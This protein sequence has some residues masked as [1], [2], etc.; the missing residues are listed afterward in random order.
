MS[1]LLEVLSTRASMTFSEFNKTFDYLYGKDIIEKNLSNYRHM[2][3]RFLEDLGHCEFDY[4]RRKVF[5]CKPE[6]ILLPGTGVMSAVLTGARIPE[7]ITKLKESQ[8][9]YQG[10]ITLNEKRQLI[11]G[12][13]LPDVITIAS[14]EK[15]LFYLVA[16]ILQIDCRCETPAA[17]MLLNASANI[18]EYE[19]T[20]LFQV[21]LAK[22]WQCRMFSTSD[23]HF[24]RINLS[25]NVYGLLEF[26]HPVTQQKTYI[27]HHNDKT[28]EI[29]K[30]WGRY[31]VLKCEG[32]S[33]LVFD[34]HKQLLGVPS[35]VPLPRLLA[36]SA[37]LCSGLAASSLTLSKTI[38][39]IPA[40]TTLDIYHG[41][42]ENMAHLLAKKVGQELASHVFPISKEGELV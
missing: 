13:P 17:W 38:R 15:Q 12:I 14:S 5:C 10:R 31:L 36:R 24:I 19:S 18:E 2:V 8:S 23:L 39:G 29:D 1:R 33:V 42:P 35:F 32:L 37:T 22:G 26:T 28:V 7:T 41:V 16:R 11:N 25:P 3:A 30:D 4:A 20:L 34:K 21:S 6:L 40:G 9:Q 27:W